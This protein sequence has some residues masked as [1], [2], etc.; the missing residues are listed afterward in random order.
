MTDQHPLVGAGA[1]R[2]VTDRLLSSNVSK[3]LSVATNTVASGMAESSQNNNLVQL[4]KAADDNDETHPGLENSFVKQ[5][6]L[7]L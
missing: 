7:R 4:G 2:I 1:S 6:E 5:Q 3:G